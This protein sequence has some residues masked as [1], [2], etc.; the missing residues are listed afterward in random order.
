MLKERDLTISKFHLSF[1][2]F[3]FLSRQIRLNSQ[4]T[5]IIIFSDIKVHITMK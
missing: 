3:F 1:A 5:Q 4:I 2:K